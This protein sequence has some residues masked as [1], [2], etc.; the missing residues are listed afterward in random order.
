MA[1][2]YASRKR[3][4]ILTLYG[5]SEWVEKIQQAVDVNIDEVTEKCFEQ[6]S[7]IV[8]EELDKKMTAKNVPQSLKSKVTS[9]KEHEG[10]YYV[11]SHGWTKRDPASF[12]KVCYLNYGTPKRFTKDGKY[13]GKIDARGFITNAK[14]AAAQRCKKAQK[15]ALNEIMQGIEKK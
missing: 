5:F 6:C 2:Q 12:A 8:T 13:R 7:E 15:D 3:N 4:Q 1:R 11:F 9:M 14:R 10:N